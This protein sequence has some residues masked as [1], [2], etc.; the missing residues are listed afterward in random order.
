MQW[1]NVFSKWRLRLPSKN[2][3]GDN[4]N[5]MDEIILLQKW[6]KAACYQRLE[7]AKNL[8]KGVLSAHPRMHE[9]NVVITK[10]GFAITD[11]G[12]AKLC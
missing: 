2:K 9:C 7:N 8:I 11:W 10:P 1:H 3:I 4:A 5:A 6:H 12:C